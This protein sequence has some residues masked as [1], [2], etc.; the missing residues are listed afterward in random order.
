MHTINHNFSTNHIIIMNNDQ[1]FPFMQQAQVYGMGTFKPGA[2]VVMTVPFD[3]MNPAAGTAFTRTGMVQ[4]IRNDFFETNWSWP[5]KII[6]YSVYFP[7]TDLLDECIE[8]W[9][10]SAYLK[11]LEGVSRSTSVS[12][13]SQKRCR[14]T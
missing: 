1:C 9:V 8:P 4:Y 3:A 2:H 11:P 7:A 14:P 6:R 10:W 5:R 13:N 12:A